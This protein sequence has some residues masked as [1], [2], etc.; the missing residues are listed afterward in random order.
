M[1]V[2]NPTPEHRRILTGL[3]DGFRMLGP[4]ESLSWF[5]EYF[6][7][8]AKA[9]AA[10]GHPIPWCDDLVREVQALYVKYK[11]IAAGQK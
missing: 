4:V 1:K 7:G 9:M 10:H 2:N 11:A 3:L 5:A 8:S 6:E